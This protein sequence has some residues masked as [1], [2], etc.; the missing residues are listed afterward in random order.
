M[1]ECR[2]QYCHFY[3]NC[4]SV[5]FKI[6]GNQFPNIGLSSDVSSLLYLALYIYVSQKG[7]FKGHYSSVLDVILYVRFTTT[8]NEVED[9]RRNLVKLYRCK[10]IRRKEKYLQF[11]INP[12]ILVQVKCISDII[13]HK[14]TWDEILR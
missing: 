6:L 13:N 5:R 10:S 1:Q 14:D 3:H 2:K 11:T 9:E 12:L 8:R 7:F 4:V